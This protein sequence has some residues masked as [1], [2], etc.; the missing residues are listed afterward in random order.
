[1]VTIVKVNRQNKKKSWKE[2]R[3]TDNTN[4][5]SFNISHSPRP[6]P[7]SPEKGIKIYI[8]RSLQCVVVVPNHLK[9]DD[10]WPELALAP[11]RAPY[12]WEQ[13]FA[14]IEFA[15]SWRTHCA[16]LRAAWSSARSQTVWDI[17]K[18]LVIKYINKVRKT[19]QLYCIKWLISAVFVI[20]PGVNSQIVISS[21]RLR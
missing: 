11:H 2:R 12:P 13:E 6:N 18:S 3:G 5:V 15:K 1:M 17:K 4:I 16:V 21:I 7:K 10:V 19:N 8:P 9:V 14:Q 20:E